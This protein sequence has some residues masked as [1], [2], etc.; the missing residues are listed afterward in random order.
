[1]ELSG[2]AYYIDFERLTQ[3]KVET[4]Y[5]RSIRWQGTDG[6][7]HEP[8]V[9]IEQDIQVFLISHACR[10]C[11]L[12]FFSF[13]VGCFQAVVRSL[14]VAAA[15][16]VSAVPRAARLPEGTSEEDVAQFNARVAH[17]CRAFASCGG[18]FTEV[19]P[20]TEEFATV[21]LKLSTNMQQLQ[22]KMAGASLFCIHRIL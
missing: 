13:L 21:S 16:E 7:L 3:S 17:A 8:A 1:M 2:S 12:L 11:F 4:G 6:A 22:G 15:A 18:M 20:D 19:N 9:P 10:S 5:T 14:D